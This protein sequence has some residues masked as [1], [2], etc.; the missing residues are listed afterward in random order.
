[1]VVK[2]VIE[3]VLD[4]CGVEQFPSYGVG[5]V[6]G[7]LGRPYPTCT[8]I[9]ALAAGGRQFDR[10]FS[11]P[12]CSPTRAA[13]FT[14][15]HPGRNG[16]GNIVESEG[17]PSL[18]DSEL[19]F[20]EVLRRYRPDVRRGGF[21]KW[22]LGSDMNGDLQSPFRAGFEVFSGTRRNLHP[23]S[24]SGDIWQTDP[25]YNMEWNVNGEYRIRL[26]QF[27]TDATINDA[28]RW[29]RTLKGQ[30]FYCYIA[31]HMPHNPFGRPPAGTYDSVAWPLATKYPANQADDELV[32]PYFKA[33]LENCDHAIGRILNELPAGELA[34]TNLIVYADNGTTSEVVGDFT[35]PNPDGS[36]YNGV[37]GAYWNNGKA[38]RTTYEGGIHVPLWIYGPS[39][40]NQIG[41]S[42]AAIAQ[43]E[44]LAVTILEM[45]ETTFPVE[46]G[47][48]IDGVSMM[49][50]IKTPTAGSNRTHVWSENFSPNGRNPGT[51]FGNRCV[52]TGQWKLMFQQGSLA[53]ATQRLF[54]ILSD[55]MELN[56]LLLSPPL[57]A[58]T[59]A[60]YD[61][62]LAYAEELAATFDDAIRPGE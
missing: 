58:G 36:E 59:Q 52:R 22:H 27:C 53:T 1:M 39:V 6:T 10:F 15:R 31:L 62:L 25:L 7:G 32:W 4:D 30:P 41:T 51:T 13:H 8:N 3:I 55:P 11:D 28:L 57:S 34:Q 5:G 26:D 23:Q 20:V 54:D 16:L 40:A 21:G 44:D 2:N 43:V 48:V 50:S 33:M 19:T 18:L 12:F 37:V 45:F 24:A 60:A 46:D 56:D 47:R 14:G 29:I 42:T 9:A 61:E 35:N 49:P 17:S 38:K